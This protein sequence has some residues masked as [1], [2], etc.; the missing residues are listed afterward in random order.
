MLHLGYHLEVSL[1]KEDAIDYL[2]IRLLTL[3][4]HCFNFT[5]DPVIFLENDGK[6]I[7]FKKSLMMVSLKSSV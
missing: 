6:R 1:F 7:V 5:N 4:Y 2:V 3:T